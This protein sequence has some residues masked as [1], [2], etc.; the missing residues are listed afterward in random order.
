MNNNTPRTSLRRRKPAAASVTARVS[1]A[2]AYSCP[3]VCSCKACITWFENTTIEKPSCGESQKTKTESR[4][5]SVRLRTW[6][7]NLHLVVFRGDYLS[8]E[9]NVA[10]E[11]IE[12][13]P[14][15]KRPN[16]IR[17]TATFRSADR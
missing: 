16:S 4:L 3:T 10:V 11:R 15:S 13:L 6:K 8:A 17:S 5:G 2:T 1:A 9:R 12:L 7:P 14:G